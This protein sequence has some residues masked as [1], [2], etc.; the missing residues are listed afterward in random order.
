MAFSPFESCTTP[1]VNSRAIT[2]AG[3]HGIESTVVSVARMSAAKSGSGPAYRFAHAGYK[4]WN[5]HSMNEHRHKVR[6][7]S[8]R[9]RRDGKGPSLVYLHGAAG[10]P[11]W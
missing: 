5:G 6:D 4:H 9:M 7:I 3:R 8:V 11:D 2:L 1:V 10:L